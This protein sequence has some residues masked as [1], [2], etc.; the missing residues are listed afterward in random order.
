MR[1]HTLSVIAILLAAGP[2]MAQDE[3]S[4]A[5]RAG[6]FAGSLCCCSLIVGIIIWAVRRFAGEFERG[7]K[8][9]LTDEEVID[10]LP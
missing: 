5:Y 8:T 4:G 1:H 6:Q 2:A 3:A 7:R 10:S 9:G